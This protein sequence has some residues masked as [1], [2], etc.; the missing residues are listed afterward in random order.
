MRA[1]CTPT[2]CWSRQ[3]LLRWFRRCRSRVAGSHLAGAFA[4]MCT[5]GRPSIRKPPTVEVPRVLTVP[6][7]SYGIFNLVRSDGV[8]LRCARNNHKNM[9]SSPL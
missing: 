8:R 7:I 3:Y 9:L 6:S 1:A 4:T 5:Q 2:A